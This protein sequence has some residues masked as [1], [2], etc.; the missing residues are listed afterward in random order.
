M[1][2]P[3]WSDWT[4]RI[5]GGA[6]PDCPDCKGSGWTDDGVASYR[7]ERCFGPPPPLHP[8][9]R[10]DIRPADRVRRPSKTIDFLDLDI[11]ALRALEDIARSTK[12]RR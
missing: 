1:N 7:C 10:C 11:S 6:D 4:F 9:C 2:A 12:P 5:G 3:E 8:N